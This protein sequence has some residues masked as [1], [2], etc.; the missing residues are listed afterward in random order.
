MQNHETNP[1][2]LSTGFSIH[3]A[4]AAQFLRRAA[5][6]ARRIERERMLWADPMARL[7]RAGIASLRGDA[8]VALAHL[9]SAQHGF[10]TTDMGL[11]AAAAKRRRGEL[12][13]GEAAETL[14]AEADAWMSR[15]GVRN[16]Q[17]MA[18]LHLPDRSP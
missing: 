13:G 16:P 10:E 4:D 12:Q 17:R 2:L 8:A 6:D 14:I 9:E 7:L 11:Y 18:A 15:Q 3:G 1:N 5:R